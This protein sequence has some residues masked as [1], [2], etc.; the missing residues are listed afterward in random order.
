MQIQMVKRH[1][2]VPQDVQSY[3]QQKV[4]RA[5]RDIPKIT[6]VKI[7][8]DDQQGLKNVKVTALAKQKEIIAEDS[9]KE[10][11]AAIDSIEDK[12]L[13][14]VRKIIKKNHDRHRSRETIQ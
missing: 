13:A 8:F 2:G 5:L 1:S 3:A 4:E 14:Q 6:D 12:L 7:I 10:F 9:S 11:K